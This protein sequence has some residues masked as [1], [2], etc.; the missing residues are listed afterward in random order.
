MDLSIFS[1]HIAGISS[2]IGRINFITTV[3]NM[4]I[5]KIE[6]IPLLA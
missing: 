6:N 2:I 1:L 5:Y 4:K 3:I